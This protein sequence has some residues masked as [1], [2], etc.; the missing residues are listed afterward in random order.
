M[1]RENDKE[2]AQKMW[3]DNAIFEIWKKIAIMAFYFLKGFL[4]DE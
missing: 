2:S 3:L 1:S 4:N